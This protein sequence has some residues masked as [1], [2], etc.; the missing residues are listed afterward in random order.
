MNYKY[1]KTPEDYAG[2]FYCENKVTNAEHEYIIYLGFPRFMIKW[3]QSE[4][5]FADYNDFCKKI[6]ELQ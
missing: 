4:G 2:F 3:K 6:A 5:M 1:T